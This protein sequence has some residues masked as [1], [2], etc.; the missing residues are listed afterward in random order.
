MTMQAI[1]ELRIYRVQPGRINDMI[2]RRQGPLKILFDRHGICPLGDWHT[3]GA[4]GEHLFVY[5]MRWQDWD[6]RQQAW[7]GFYNDPF[8]WSE[9][10]RTNAGSELVERY[11]LSFLKEITPWGMGGIESYHALELVMPRIHIGHSVLVAKD[12]QAYTKSRTKDDPC[13]HG[14]FEFLT[15]PDLPSSALFVGHFADPVASGQV[16]QRAVPSLSGFEKYV[17]HPIST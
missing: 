6:T 2:A 3:L 12:L 13:L 10:E 14:S 5:L 16:I 8:W 15:G 17:L 1:Y 7:A 4:G 11:R 9:R